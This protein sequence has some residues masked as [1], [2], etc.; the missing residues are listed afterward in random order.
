MGGLLLTPYFLLLIDT[1]HPAL[2]LLS[3]TESLNYTSVTFR[4]LIL[5][6]VQKPAPLTDQLQE[7]PPGMMVLLVGFEVFRQ[8]LDPGTQEGDLDLRRPRIF[9]V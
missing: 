6:I 9:F 1:R 5:H 8:I 2:R 4:V 7:T 3:Q